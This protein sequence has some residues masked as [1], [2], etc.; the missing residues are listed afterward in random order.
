MYIY[1]LIVTDWPTETE[2]ELNTGIYWESMS[3]SRKQVSKGY[4]ETSTG[5]E[6]FRSVLS[7][8]SRRSWMEPLWGILDGIWRMDRR[9]GGLRTRTTR[10]EWHRR[11]VKHSNTITMEGSRKWVQWCLNETGHWSELVL[12]LKS[13]WCWLLEWLAGGGD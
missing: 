13:A 5:D 4:A 2:R 1:R 12:V 8:G 3:D 10:W 9:R 6:Q 11:L 7:Y